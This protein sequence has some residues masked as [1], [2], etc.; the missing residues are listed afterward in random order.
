MDPTDS[1]IK[2]DQ[3]GQNSQGGGGGGNGGGGESIITNTTGHT[4]LPLPVRTLTSQMRTYSKKHL[5]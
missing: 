1:F 3:L 4:T 2:N 5:N